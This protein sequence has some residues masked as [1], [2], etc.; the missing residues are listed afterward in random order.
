MDHDLTDD[1]QNILNA[2]EQHD[3]LVDRAR[4]AKRIEALETIEFQV[5]DR[6]ENVMYVHGY[7][8]DLAALYQRGAQHWQRLTDINEHLFECLR[9]EVVTSLN[10]TATLRQQINTYIGS[11][12]R[13]DPVGYDDLDIFINGLFGIDTEPEETRPL[14][15]GMIGY[16]ATP[17]RFIFELVERL[18]LEPADVFYDL[19]AGVGRVALLVGLLTPAEVRGIEYDPG[20]CA[21]AQQCAQHLPVPRVR[22]IN[23]DAQEADFSD[24]TIFFMYTPFRGDLLHKVLSRLKHEVYR[25]PMT[26]AT[27]GPCTIDVAQLD[28]LDQLGSGEPDD[29]SLTLFRRR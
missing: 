6:I 3:E 14:R 29:R 12:S 8:A 24:G 19:G 16:Q 11:S 7:Q 10:P 4:F 13:R 21:Y 25:R 26:L 1:I 22:F 20:H 23:A 5:L 27:Y 15:P 2:I 9:E 18:P 17:A 28:W